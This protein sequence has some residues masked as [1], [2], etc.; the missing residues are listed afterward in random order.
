AL[1]KEESRVKVPARPK[2]RDMS[3]MVARSSSHLAQSLAKGEQPVGAS[4][5]AR[6][7]A[8]SPPTVSNNVG[9]A[10]M[11]VTVDQLINVDVDTPSWLYP[12]ASSFAV[13]GQGQVGGGPY[14]VQC[15]TT[16]L[17]F[18]G[19]AIN[20]VPAT[21]NVCPP[22]FDHQVMALTYYNVYSISL[23]S[24]GAVG[25]YKQVVSE[26]SAL[27]V[28]TVANPASTTQGMAAGSYQVGSGLVQPASAGQLQVFTNNKS[29][30]GT[31]EYI[32]NG[33]SCPYT[34]ATVYSQSNF[35]AL[36]LQNANHSISMQCVATCRNTQGTTSSPVYEQ[37]LSSPRTQVLQ[38]TTNIANGSD[39]S[40][41]QTSSSEWNV[42][43]NLGFFGGTP[44][45]GFNGGYSSGSSTTNTTGGNYSQSTSFTYGN[46][47]TDVS[48]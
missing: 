44:T 47:V 11:Q 22:E 19:V 32:F 35:S 4:A 25:T 36:G 3:A 29:T 8:F 39:W 46:W 13:Q 15:S 37:E 12:F 24:T 40:L 43:G 14:P 38:G 30:C 41:S 28:N 34:W 48:P 21:G 42:G 10:T 33:D 27:Q 26:A 5:N 1:K 23:K 16:P 31:L 6:E 17:T 9:L 7:Q 45:G 18:G 2:A 20:F